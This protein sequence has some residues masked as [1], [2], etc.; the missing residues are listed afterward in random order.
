M[1]DKAAEAAI[2]SNLPV[3]GPDGTFFVRPVLDGEIADGV[4]LAAQHLAQAVVPEDLLR[5]VRN[6]NPDSLWGIFKPEAQSGE[7]PEMI[8]FCSFLS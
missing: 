2:H 7:Q 1:P 8:G 3:Y 5:R 4:A 6:H